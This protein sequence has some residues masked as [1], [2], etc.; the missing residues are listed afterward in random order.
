MVLIQIQKYFVCPNGAIEGSCSSSMVG[1]KTG[2]ASCEEAYNLH[3]IS[4][5]NCPLGVMLTH[6]CF[7]P[8]VI[9]LNC[10]L[11]AKI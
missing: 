10:T 9:K 4:S 8:T 5:L 3:K 2:G 7:K 6:N 11:W 1:T